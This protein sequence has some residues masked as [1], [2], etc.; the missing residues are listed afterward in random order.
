VSHVMPCFP[1][2]ASYCG[3]VYHHLFKLTGLLPFHGLLLAGTEMK[4]FHESTG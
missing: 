4:V 2:S 3:T 1:S